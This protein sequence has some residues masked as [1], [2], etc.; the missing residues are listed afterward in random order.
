MRKLLFVLSA[1]ASAIAVV[2]LYGQSVL[3][4]IL[5]M[6]PQYEASRS[7]D[8][9]REAYRDSANQYRSENDQDLRRE[10]RRT[11]VAEARL[12]GAER[13]LQ[14]EMNRRGMGD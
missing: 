5:R 12:R 3:D 11:Q 9:E 14:D 2:P 10:Q 7:E 13:A 8:A 4:K 6:Q 1:G